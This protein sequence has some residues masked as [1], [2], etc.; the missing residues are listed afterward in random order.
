MERKRPVVRCP[1][2][3]TANGCRAEAR[4]GWRVL[5]RIAIVGVATA[6][7]AATDRAPATGAPERPPPS[8]LLVTLDTTRADALSSYREG[9]PS[10]LAAPIVAATPSLDA[11][12]A[13]GVRFARAVSAC[14]LTLPAHA[15]LLT[16]LEPPAHGLRDNGIGALPA[17]VPTLAATLARRGYRAAAFVGSRVLDRRFGLGRGFAVYDDRMA[18]ERTSA[19][20][21]PERDAAAVTD[22]A[23]AWL[24]EEG[25]AAGPRLLWVHYY[26]PHAPYEPPGVPVDAPAEARYAGEV[27]FVDRELGRLLRAL[28][29]GAERWLVAA[30]GDHG[31]GFGEHGERG[32][33][34][35]LHREALEVP[36]ILAGPGVPRGRVVEGLVP[37][38]ALAASLLAL[39][40][41]SAD[42]GPFGEPLPGLGLANEPAAAIPI[43]SET[44]LPATA[45]GWSA[46]RALTR[47]P[48]RLV[49]A[50]R[51][52]LFDVVVDPAER[53]D[54]AAE[55]GSLVRRLRRELE[56]LAVA[57]G[58]REAETLADDA[59]LRETLAGLGY[60]SGAS[61]GERAPRAAV[62]PERI[63]P[64]DGLALLARYDETK[65]LL[66]RGEHSRA[67]A[68]LESLVRA[69]P[70]NVPF[71]TALGGVLLR[72]GDGDK[73]LSA[74]RRAVERNPGADFAHVNLGQ[75]LAEL[76]RADEARRAFGAA[77]ERNPRFA[78]AWLAL[79]ALEQ[80]AGRPAAERA[81]L[82]S[83]VAAG[84]DSAA[85][86]TRL[87]QIELAAGELAAAESHLAAATR[88]A[89]DWPPA[90]LVRGEVAL[91]RGDRRVARGWLERAVELDPRSAGG[92]LRLGE[93]LLGD[94]ETVAARR[95]LE[96]AVAAEPG[97]EAASR[98]RRLLV[99]D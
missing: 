63:D 95:L 81:V 39:L 66:A 88:L 85:I 71:L 24:G 23:L 18:A 62:D 34:V 99:R 35:L 53:R 20:G 59:E 38:R 13:G 22:A 47:S 16:G 84:T 4:T 6:A 36:L 87:G 31:E 29:D 15:S 14:P 46:L 26:D 10:T 86:R 64:K 2:A 97:S 5:L 8:L 91:A 1:R 72:A 50:P 32:H 73:A 19:Q 83:A 41:L 43:Y 28:P 61:G 94:G 69:N 7:G 96:R 93:L 82:D 90:W 11:L 55:R 45:Y 51:S 77:L 65:R 78:R 76:G 75:A 56:A 33:G 68:E 49:E 40:G 52:E 67:R 54:L 44:L 48:Y 58:A 60:L 70:E 37:T 30:V 42:A 98:A 74:Y 9:A 80:R 92:L 17:D 57:G 21:D 25:G 3:D 89:P 27:G 79:A 12:A